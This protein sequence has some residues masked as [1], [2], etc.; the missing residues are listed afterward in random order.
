MN[1]HEAQLKMRLLWYACC[2]SYMSL[3]ACTYSFTALG[4]V[5]LMRFIADVEAVETSTDPLLED[6]SKHKKVTLEKALA[7]VRLWCTRP[8]VLLLAPIQVTFGVC[9]ALLGQEVTGTIIPGTYKKDG[10]IVGS[11][12]GTLVSFTAGMLQ[13]CPP[14][15]PRHAPPPV[16]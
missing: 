7:A 8:T 3:Y 15:P 13:A 14:P 16:P 5:V 9:A 2:G 6:R 10:V 1:S 12:M 11:L 4:A